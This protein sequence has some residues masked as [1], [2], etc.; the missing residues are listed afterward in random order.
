MN[1]KKIINNC[2]INFNYYD[3]H[4][5][6]TIIF[7][8]GW[9]QNIAMMEVI[10]KYYKDYFNILVLDLPGFG[11]S[12]EPDYA[13][14]V[15]DYA[16]AINTLVKELKIAKVILVGHSFG[17]RVALAYASKYSVLK[18]VCF[19]SPYCREIEKLPLKSRIYKCLKKVKIFNP[20]TKVLSNFIGS[21]DYREASQTMRGVLVK[22]IN[23]DMVDDIKKIKS[24]TLF[25]WGDKDTAVPLK[26]AYELKELVADSAV[27]VYK[28]ATHYAYL[29]E[30]N[31][32]IAILDSFFQVKRGE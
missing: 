11:N 22:A 21:K 10:S 20:L 32:T 8:H 7:L 30:I 24:P 31:R 29:E 17:G 13:W 14:G 16:T 23:I 4:K 15:F 6:E 9:G 1:M 27:I 25:I 2:E 26:R 3:S 28:N 19:A 5:S 12:A 18:M